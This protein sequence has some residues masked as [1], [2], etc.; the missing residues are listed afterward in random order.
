MKVL[1]GEIWMADLNP[2]QG[3]EQAGCRP[4]VVLSG[5][6]LNSIMPVVFVAPLTSRIKRF[7]GNPIL[8]PDNM[9]GLRQ[10]SELLV[11]HFRSISRNRLREKVGKVRRETVRTAAATLNDLLYY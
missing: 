4:V 9:N 2:A 10:P 8:E 7:K 6:M 1:Q 3:S 11:F 5:N